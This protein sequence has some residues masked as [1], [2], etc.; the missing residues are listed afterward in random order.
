MEVQLEDA[1]VINSK[2]K[3]NKVLGKFPVHIIEEPALVTNSPLLF[4]NPY[5]EPKQQC[6]QWMYFG[7]ERGTAA[8][9]ESR[10]RCLPYSS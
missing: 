4:E 10:R 3:Y 9:A 6:C 8:F 5:G 1:K 2:E 7:P